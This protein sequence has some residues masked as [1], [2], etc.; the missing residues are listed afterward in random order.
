MTTLFT[1][2]QPQV[3][4]ATITIQS[5]GT[6]A[7]E[8]LTQIRRYFHFYLHCMLLW[9]LAR[10]NLP[11]LVLSPLSATR[12]AIAVKNNL[13][14]KGERST[15]HMANSTSKTNLLVNYTSRDEVCTP[16]SRLTVSISFIVTQ[17]IHF[18]CL[19]DHTILSEL[20]AKKSL[21]IELE[22]SYQEIQVGLIRVCD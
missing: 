12:C 10:S 8:P 7:L 21:W 14:S 22:L 9:W 1:S 18:L 3:T 20:V 2:E 17:D 15:T 6:M 5:L 11:T 19:I 16:T 13:K 4:A